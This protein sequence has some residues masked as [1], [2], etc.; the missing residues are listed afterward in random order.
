MKISYIKRLLAV[1][2]CAMCMPLAGSA[3][4]I[5]LPSDITGY[6]RQ[7]SLADASQGW[8]GTGNATVQDVESYFPT[9][10]PWTER[11]S[12]S[13]SSGSGTGIY[14]GNA[15]TVNVLTGS[16]G[17]TDV[18][19]TWTINDTSFWSSYGNAAI[20][21]HVGN[22]AGDPDHFVWLIDQG[23]TTGTWSYRVFSGGGGGLSNLKLYSSGT[24][25]KVPDGGYTLV[26]VGLAFS[27]LGL[28][29]RKKT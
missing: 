7:A 14:E 5:T 9:L 28:I 18:T 26:L 27:G 25:T 10:S 3:L 16:F 19:G 24:A 11:G 4:T 17:G 15:L 6:Q 1:A 21:M 2:V 8:Y 23:K 13:P 20:S 12:V 29:C 22:G